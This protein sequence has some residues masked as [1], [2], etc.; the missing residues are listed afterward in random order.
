MARGR[1]PE[2]RAYF[3]EYH[4]KRREWVT[5]LKTN[6]PCMDCGVAFH[7]AAMQFDHRPG[8]QKRFNVGNCTHHPRVVVE[9]EI[10]K[11]DLVCANCHAV[12]TFERRRPA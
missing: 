12:R 1:T 5:Q 9:A 10:A 8:E 2:G 4:K 6:S 3:R 11:C 7:P